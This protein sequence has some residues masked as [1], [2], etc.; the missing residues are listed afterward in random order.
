MK[1]TYNMQIINNTKHTQI[2]EIMEEKDYEKR[3]I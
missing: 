1:I 3:R 2:F